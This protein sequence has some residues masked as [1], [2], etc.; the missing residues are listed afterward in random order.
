MSERLKGFKH[1]KPGSEVAQLFQEPFGRKRKHYIGIID[2]VDFIEGVIYI[3][4]GN[5][6]R[7]EDGTQ[8]GGFGA[9]PGRLVELTDEVRRE[10]FRREA[11]STLQRAIGYDWELMPDEIIRQILELLPPPSKH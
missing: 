10:V 1:L 5:R 4:G 3:K 7:L 11:Q 2:S 8:K 6:Y 9:V